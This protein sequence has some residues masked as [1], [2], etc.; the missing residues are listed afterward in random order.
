MASR[1]FPD[2]PISVRPRTGWVFLFFT[3]LVTAPVGIAAFVPVRSTTAA[4]AVTALV[5]T[6]IAYIYFVAPRVVVGEDVIRVENSWR[7]HVVPWGALVDV[8]TRFSLTL[9]TA[10][11]RIHAQAAP[12]PSGLMAM[13]GRPDHDAA[14]ARVNAQRSGPV[15][16]GDVPNSLSGSLAA[17]IRGHCQD[18]LEADALET[19]EQARTSPRV[20]H[21][22]LTLGGLALATVLWLL[23]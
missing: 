11:G 19:G 16:P 5:L 20:T 10:Q 2:G 8:E 23:A 12:G 18:L 6:A 22:A 4:M 17:V 9:V 21:L 14:T 7:E 3:M 15:H 1:W 13:R